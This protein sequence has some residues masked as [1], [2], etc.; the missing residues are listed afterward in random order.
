MKVHIKGPS[1]YKISACTI[2]KNEENTISKSIDSYKYFVDE[3]IVLDTG[4]TDD[5]VKVARE[6]GATVYHYQWNNDFAAAKNAALDHATGDWI[7]FLDA[8]EYFVEDCGKRVRDAIVEAETRGD[9]S[10]G[11]Q[12]ININKKTGNVIAE[13]FSTRVMKRG[14]RYKFSVHEEPV[15][16]DG[17]DI[18]IADKSWFFLYHTGYDPEVVEAKAK[19]NLDIMLEQ[20]ETETDPARKVVYKSYLSDSY[21]VMRDHENTIKYA[22]EF[23]ESADEYDIRLIGCETKPYLN[24]LSSLEATD[25]DINEIEIWVNKL[26]DRFPDYPDGLLARGRMFIQKKMFN[27]ALAE[28]DKTQKFIKNYSDTYP[29]AIAGNPAE[30]YYSYGLVYE[31][32]LNVPE[33]LKWYYKSFDAKQENDLAL[34]NLFR[35]IKDMPQNNIDEL[36]DPLYSGGQRKCK[37]ILTALMQNYMSNQIL[38]C[39][40]VYRGNKTKDI[41]SNVSG[42]IMAGK[43]DYSGA[44]KMFKV[45]Y[46]ILKDSDTAARALVTAFLSKRQD[47]IEE[48]TTICTS[49]QLFALGLCEDFG[50]DSPDVK[51][52]ARTINELSILKG[53]SFSADLTKRVA[54]SLNEKDLFFLVYRLEKLYSYEAAL[55]AI[56]CAEIKPYTV[57]MQ[58]YFLYRLHRFNES[59]D[60]LNLAKHMGY[61]KPELS[62]VYVSLKKFQIERDNVTSSHNLTQLKQQIENEINQGL[63][64]EAAENIMKY[65]QIAEPDVDIFTAEAAVMYYCG[66]Y[67]KAIIAVESGLLRDKKNFD[68]LY[69][70]GCIYDKL[71]DLSRAASM[72]RMALANCE[73]EKI[74]ENIKLSLNLISKQSAE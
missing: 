20:M 32:L 15:R 51:Q 21:S 38:K 3:I 34:T 17:K 61:D 73:S 8:D 43:G 24:L 60:L 33:A 39:Y 41:D 69:N 45:A 16:E 10:V 47:F 12:M 64:S 50:G 44:A 14:F 56:Q 5:T 63:Y 70:A 18:L 58:G 25:A 42:F 4:S 74:A 53:G 35:L 55:T 49:S 29:S 68:L 2:A 46:D 26:N 23:I 30:L 13:I 54:A 57:F 27:S 67:K 7:I 62:E 9:G 19:R 11:C 22:T 28:F 71:G 1:D 59:A 36:A 65:K 37:V 72:Y 48:C 31:G 40:P 66:D 52:I 6:H